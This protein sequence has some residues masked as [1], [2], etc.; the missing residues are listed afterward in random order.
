MPRRG[1]PRRVTGPARNS[2]I[3]GLGAG[4]SRAE[5]FGE[6]AQRSWLRPGS[7]LPLGWFRD[8]GRDGRGDQGFEIS[9]NVWD[10]WCIVTLV[11]RALSLSIGHAPLCET[12]AAVVPASK[13]PWGATARSPFLPRIAPNIAEASC[14][15]RPTRGFDVIR[16]A[17]T[18]QQ[19]D[20][21]R[22]VSFLFNYLRV[23]RRL[24]MLCGA[25][26]C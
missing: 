11:R 22:N 15:E 9:L 24:R 12:Q 21:P 18:Q 3:F 26:E 16:T 8:H 17:K 7:S 10:S 19:R 25:R 20:K 14:V 13:G 5:L 1:K 2:S 6:F 23:R 4:I